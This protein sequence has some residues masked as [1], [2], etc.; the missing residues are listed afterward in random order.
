MKILHIT[1]HMGGGLGTVIL[2]WTGA[3][4]GHKVICLD[5]MNEKAQSE[6]RVPFKQNMAGNKAGMKRWVNEAD[7]V[8]V[9]WYDSLLLAGLFPLPPCRLVFWCH[10]NYPVPQKELDYP[11][12]FIDTS[13]IQG[14]GKHIWSTGGV[15]RFL[16]VKPRPHKGFTVGYVGTIDYKKLHPQFIEMCKAINIPDVTFIMVGENNIGKELN[17]RAIFTNKVDDVAPYLAEMD[18]FGYPLRPDH[19]GT[20]E[21][22]LGEAMAAGVVPVVMDNPAEKLIVED[23][24]TGFIAKH[25]TEYC[26]IINFIYN[27]YQKTKCHKIIQSLNARVSA[28]KLYSIDTMIKRWD[29]VFEELM[30]KPKRPRGSLLL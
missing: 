22:V 23:N 1:S 10:K 15:D 21:Q 26:D 4:E 25:E 24:V 9:H 13:P 16:E 7:I 28:G 30:E 19:Y 2:G 20:S 18:V 11:D 6:I 8:V 5:Y 17:D 27:N 12:L 29:E 3:T 14:H